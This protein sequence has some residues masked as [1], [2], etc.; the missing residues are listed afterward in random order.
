[1]TSLSEVTEAWRSRSVERRRG[2]EVIELEVLPESALRFRAAIQTAVHA[3]FLARCLVLL[4][5]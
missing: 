2:V 4:G 5:Q 1:M 3:I